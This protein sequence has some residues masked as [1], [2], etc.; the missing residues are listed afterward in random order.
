[1]RV[2]SLA[3]RSVIRIVRSRVDPPAPYVTDTNVGRSGSSS[4]M[5][6]QSWASPSSSFGGKNSNETVRSCAARSS[7]IVG[8]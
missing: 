2:V 1:M 7:R 8:A 5:A 6:R 4:L 3:I